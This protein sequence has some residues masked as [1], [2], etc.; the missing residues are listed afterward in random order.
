[1]AGRRCRRGARAA[2]LLIIATFA[3]VGLAPAAASAASPGSTLFGVVPES[4]QLTAGD[5]AWM[6]AGHV[7]SVRFVLNWQTVQPTPG[8]PYKWGSVDQE[9]ETLALHGITPLPQLFGDKSMVTQTGNADMMNRWSKFVSAAVNRYK[10]GSAYWQWFQSKHPGATPLPPKVWQVY[11]E[12]NIPEFWPG[13]PSPNKY[14]VLLDYSATAIRGADPTAKIMLGGMHGENGMNG[15]PSWTFL[16]GLYEYPGAA[17]DFDIVAVHPYQATVLGIA[18]EVG[19]VRG[20]MNGKGDQQSPIWITEMGWS[21]QLDPVNNYWWEQ[22]PQGQA[23]M[24]ESSWKF[25]LFVRNIW[26]IG[27]IYWYTWRDPTTDTCNF[28]NS[29]GLLGKNYYPKPSYGAF[30]RLATAGP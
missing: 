19:L 11:N 16:K 25:L 28:C 7:G 29:A 21:S 6:D 13:G 27:G 20:T 18:Q 15:I 30:R 23:D 26:N 17:D 4:N 2:L 1:L 24:L 22:T 8:G 5:L 10:A 14:A 3:A 9:L 12:Q